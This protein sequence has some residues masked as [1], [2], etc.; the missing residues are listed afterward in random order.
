MSTVPEVAI[1]GAGPYG[2]SA[3]AHLRAAG[4]KATIFG[5]TM[6]FWERQMPAECLFPI[7]LKP[8]S[9]DQPSRFTREKAWR[10]SN[11]AE[12]LSRHDEAGALIK[13][14]SIMLQ[15]LIP[16]GGDRQ[17]AY[18][19]LCVDGAPLASVVA[20]GRR[21]HPIDF[22]QSSS[23]VESVEEPEVE[24]L[25]CVVLRAIPYSGLVEV[26]FKRDP[27]DDQFR[28]LDVNPRVWGWHT[29]GAAAGVDFTYLAWQLANGRQISET[30]VR[31]GVKWVRAVT[32]ALAVLQQLR[33][34][35]F[36]LRDYVPCL[37]SPGEAAIWTRD[38]RLPALSEIP[39]L[40]YACYRIGRSIRRPTYATQS[41]PTPGAIADE[42]GF[43][44]VEIGS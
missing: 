30:R 37:R 9:K 10:V 8:S 23:F 1:I 13:P 43:K 31:P 5:H 26:E 42:A 21:Q 15:D 2:L 12:M 35:C 25:A 3:A 32:D 39:A 16:G 27:R 14:D 36:S 22:G 38:D 6:G 24:R 33:A 19:A 20:M 17:F 40:I 4:V 29:L 11:R 18:A 34:G 44:H 28:L 7:L 41:T